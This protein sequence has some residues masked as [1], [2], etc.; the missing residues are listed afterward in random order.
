VVKITCVFPQLH[1]KM[2][3]LFIMNTKPK[4]SLMRGLLI[5]LILVGTG[6][7]SAHRPPVKLPERKPVNNFK[8]GEDFYL[9]QE[10]DKAFKQ[11]DIFIQNHPQDSRTPLAYIRQGQILIVQLKYTEAQQLLE[12]FLARYPDNPQEAEALTQLGSCFYNL[13]DYRRTI[14]TFKRLLDKYPL[15]GSYDI[16]F[17]IAQSFFKLKDYNNAVVRFQ[18]VIDRYPAAG[19]LSELNYSLGLAAFSI[20]KYELAWKSLQK[21]AEEELYP[22]EGLNLQLMLAELARLREDYWLAWTRLMS[23]WE[24]MQKVTDSQIMK[25]PDEVQAL[26]GELIAERFDPD[27]LMEVKERYPKSFPGG[28][29]ILRLAR[30][31][32]EAM[33]YGRAQALLT[34]FFAAFPEH[35]RYQEAQEL[36][37]KIEQALLVDKHKIGL[38]IPLSGKLS[39]Y[40]N[41]VLK[42][43]EL[44]V[45]EENRERESKLSL[46]I[47]DSAGK[48]ALAAQVMQQLV[49]EDQV[50]GVIGPVLSNSV[51]A[52]G[53]VANQLRTPIITPTASAPGIPQLGPY[54]FR[55][56]ITS[57]QQ[58]QAIAEFAIEKM[59]LR[60]FAVLYPKNSYG[61]EFKDIFISYVNQLGGKVLGMATYGEEETDFRWQAEY[62]SN[63]E[64]EAIFIPDYA[65]K[66]VLIAPQL[67]FYATRQSMADLPEDVVL[68]EGESQREKEQQQALLEAELKKET[69]SEWWMESGGIDAL[70]PAI[71]PQQTNPLEAEAAGIEPQAQEAPKV[72]LLG[73]NGW[74]SPKLVQEG[75]KFVEQ[76]VFPAGFYENSPSPVVQGF[77]GRFRERFRQAPN[78]LAAQAYDAA[79]MVI[80]ALNG[81]VADRDDLQQALLNIVDFPG[82]SGRTSFTPEGDSQKE[83]F[84]IGVKHKRFRQL[85]GDEKWLCPSPP[86]MA[87]ENEADDLDDPVT[88]MEAEGL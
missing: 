18:A 38:I 34:E 75:D 44:A 22:A 10:F 60:E 65:D 20:G 71:L 48:P 46:I 45:E 25:T 74:Y 64:P 5:L 70:P 24:E 36:Q 39:V 82:V 59:C 27:Q 72:I 69:A 15:K 81:E 49:V 9:R 2:V 77:I 62:L 53:K 6:C 79:R 19:E 12:R 1:F 8:Q 51:R 50:I 57:T 73:T 67:A 52:A 63:I 14:T 40:G 42:G 61:I 13:E 7:A 54:V 11:F 35:P 26:I 3:G 85:K 76:A 56:C 32:G 29:A 88:G 23:A 17:M 84:L 37:Q 43:V 16:Y 4:V 31:A 80:H 66:V 55:N 68:D 87:Q 41:M 47:K 30:I 86:D 21:V 78:L 83:L 28:E 58:G 33:D